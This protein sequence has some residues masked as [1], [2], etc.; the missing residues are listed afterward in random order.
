M[1]MPDTRLPSSARGN[2]AW[3]CRWWG[4]DGVVPIHRPGG[5][6]G[7]V[8]ARR[9]FWSWDPGLRRDDGHMIALRPGSVALAQLRAIWEGAPVELHA[10]AWHAIDASAASIGRILASGRT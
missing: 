9:D 5:G 3:T 1:P 6:R 7:L 10:D 8:E 2:R 4:G